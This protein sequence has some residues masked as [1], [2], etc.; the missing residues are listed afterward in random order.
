M[1][2]GK[3]PGGLTAIAVLNFVFGGFAVIGTLLFLTAS[4]LVNKAASM[5]HEMGGDVQTV[6][7]GI[8]YVNLLLLAA[9]V[10]ALLLIASGVGYIKHEEVPRSD[11]RQ[12]VRGLL[13]RAARSISLALVHAGFGI[14]TIIGLDLP[15]V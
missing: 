13:D 12:R 3:R 5:G 10:D 9:V 15:G 7:M 6:G 11:A 14:G 1:A 4:I 2:D 8:L